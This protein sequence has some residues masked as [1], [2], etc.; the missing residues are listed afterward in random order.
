MPLYFF[1]TADGG[2]LTRDT[3]GIEL[4]DDEAARR[5]GIS[6]LPDMAHDV[7]PDGGN[8]HSFTVVVRDTTRRAIFIA[9]LTL[10]GRW[11]T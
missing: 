9:D 1:D 7:L 5:Y 6:A 4:P 2:G 10:A 3:D 8:L 11:L